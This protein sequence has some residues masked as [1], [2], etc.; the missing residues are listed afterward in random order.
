MKNS[1]I[2]LLFSVLVFIYVLLNIYIPKNKTLDN[3][4]IGIVKNIKISNDIMTIEVNNTLIKSNII[5]IN[6]GD[7]IKVTGTSKLPPTN[8]IFNLF[9]YRNYLL[10]KKIYTIM[11]S[12]KII[13][14]K[15]NHNLFYKSKTF[16]INYF[17]K[18]KSKEY[19]NTFILGNNIIEEEYKKSFI[20]NGISHLFAISGMHIS[21]FSNILLFILSKIFKSDKKVYLIITLFLIFYMFLTSFSPSVLRGSF[22]FIILGFIKIYK[23]NIKAIDVLTYICGIMLIYNPFYI[24][25][26]GFLYSFIISF[27]LMKFSSICTNKSY[28]INTLIISLISFLAS[29]PISIITNF[30]I[31]LISPLINVIFVPLISLIIFPLSL[32]TLFLPILDNLLHVLTNIMENMSLVISKINCFII[33]LKNMNILLVILYYLLITYILY[34]IKKKQYLYI[35][36]IIIILFIHNN[37][38]YLN[39]YPILTMIDVGQGDSILIILPHNKGN[40]LIDTGG[41]DYSNYSI[42]LNKTITYLKSEGIKQLD[43][44][45]L[46]HGDADHAIETNNLYNN[47]K[48]K[49]IILNSGKFNNIELNIIDNKKYLQFSKNIL[50][51]NGYKFYFLNDIDSDNENED[52]L[53]I[54]TKLNNYNLLFMGD[55]GISSENYIMNTYKLPKMDILKVGHH[56][57]KNSSGIKFLEKINPKISL[58]SAGLNNRFSHPHKEVISN[59]NKISSD[60]YITSI[61]GSIKIILKDKL[62]I[63]TCLDGTLMH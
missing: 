34:K 13:I 18:F 31:N 23:I 60:T 3:E 21:L 29:I 30:Q 46:T 24:Y 5:D 62:I 8:T 6:L 49:N 28:I 25:N 51:V 19:L 14:I 53:I 37:I 40:I 9:N 41:N 45:I 32:L 52:S 38:N 2:K 20:T 58:I 44:L 56:G 59:L 10:I 63:N 43:Y 55:A 12:D 54:Y 61:N 15:K 27:Y 7:K 50:N 35:I 42:V 26:T 36:C 17:N 4:I 33:I 11:E 1:K 57:S 16:L 47:F 39:K 22:L 48:V